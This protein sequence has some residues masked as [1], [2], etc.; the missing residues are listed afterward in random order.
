MLI[1]TN[2]MI[3][4]VNDIIVCVMIMGPIQI[5]LILITSASFVHLPK[6]SCQ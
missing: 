4:Y 2:T 6:F 1:Y 5:D 3:I